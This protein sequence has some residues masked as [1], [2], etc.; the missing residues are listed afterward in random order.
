MRALIA[1]IV[2]EAEDARIA[3]RH[4]LGILLIPLALA[5]GIF[6]LT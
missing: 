4:M 1:L 6:I 3:R 5:V 2:Q